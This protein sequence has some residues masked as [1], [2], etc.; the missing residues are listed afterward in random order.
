MSDT[1]KLRPGALLNGQLTPGSMAREIA[2]ALDA[3]VPPHPKEDPTA[4]QKLALAIAQGVIKHLNDN[5][6]ALMVNVRD[7][8]TGSPITRPVTVDVG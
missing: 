3:L 1:V 2:D 4:R 8:T 5:E 6:G 7:S